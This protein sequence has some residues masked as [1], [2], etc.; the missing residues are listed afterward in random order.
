MKQFLWNPMNNN[1]Y[2][3][4]ACKF[5]EPI[6]SSPMA[7]CAPMCEKTV[8][9]LLC[10]NLNVKSATLPN[11]TSSIAPDDL[12]TGFH[13]SVSERFVPGTKFS[14][15]HFVITTLFLMSKTRSYVQML[16]G[17]WL[18]LIVM[19]IHLSL[20][21]APLDLQQGGNSRILYVR[22]PVAQMSILVYIVTAINTFL[23]LLTKHPLFLRPSGTGTEMGAC[24]MLFTL[25]TGGFRGR[26]TWSTF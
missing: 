3:G 13:F 1:D 26:P 24:Y 25:V 2:L 22:V 5:V 17:S 23:F 11:A 4:S 18:F 21:A 12:V 10:R 6:E 16:I 8:Q 7:R 14:H 19:A 15:G 9:A 20:W